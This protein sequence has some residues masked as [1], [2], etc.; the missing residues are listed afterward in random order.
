MINI[1]LINASITFI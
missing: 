1:D